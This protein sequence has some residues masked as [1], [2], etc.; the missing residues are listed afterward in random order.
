MK[1]TLSL[2]AIMALFTPED[3]Q[4]IDLRALITGDPNPGQHLPAIAATD[5]GTETGTTETTT[6]TTTA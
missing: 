6:E 1:F 4:A 3:V 5:D 2:L